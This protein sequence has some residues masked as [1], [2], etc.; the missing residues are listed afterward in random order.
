MPGG[1]A[2]K[3]PGQALASFLVTSLWGP[4]GAL[5]ACFCAPRL[6]ILGHLEARC[7]RVLLSCPATSLCADCSELTAPLLPATPHPSPP[8]GPSPAS[9]ALPPA[10]SLAK[11][12]IKL[13]K[14]RKSYP[15]T[16]SSTF[17]HSCQ[18]RSKCGFVGSE[19][20]FPTFF[21]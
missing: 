21:M 3:H 15:V 9:A 2:T 12:A 10:S 7:S 4:S 6:K 18:L 8:H 1:P 14:S 5:T 20:N 16:P 17:L 13:H 11:Q 19:L